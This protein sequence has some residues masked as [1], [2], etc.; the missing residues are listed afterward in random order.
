MRGRTAILVSHH[1]HLCA[2]GAGYVVALD[3][4]QVQFQGSPESFLTS[5]L[6]N[7]LILSAPPN[8]L[9]TVKGPN[10][11]DDAADQKFS[12]KTPDSISE[13]SE[14][15]VI[16]SAEQTV[17]SSPRRFVEEELRAVGAVKDNVWYTY[18]CACGSPLYWSL[19]SLV[20]VAAAISPVLENTWLR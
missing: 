17:K 18:F 14:F 5:E 7:S 6:G 10:V 15:T 1:V 9:D 2:P 3:H 8:L 19:L 13:V 4:G 20:L 11:P 12:G 16:S